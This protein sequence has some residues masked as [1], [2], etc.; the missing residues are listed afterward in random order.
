MAR[1]RDALAAVGF[2]PVA[3]AWHFGDQCHCACFVYE[4]RA[5]SALSAVVVQ[6]REMDRG[7]CWGKERRVQLPR[8]SDGGAH[9]K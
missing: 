8:D 6:A 2:S 9:A 5:S 4:A 3:L 1:R 7:V